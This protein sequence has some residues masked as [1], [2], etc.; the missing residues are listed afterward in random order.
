MEAG[1]LEQGGARRLHRGRGGADAR[2]LPDRQ[3][4]PAPDVGPVQ[5][6]S[7]RGARQVGIRHHGITLLSAENL[8]TGRV[9]DWFMR[10]EEVPRA[11]RAA[12]L[13]RGP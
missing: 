2:G 11:M 5:R 12:G 4:D 9:W 6:R 1:V 8:R 10:N 13:E 3:R 7:P